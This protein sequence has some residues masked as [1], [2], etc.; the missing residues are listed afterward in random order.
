MKAEKLDEVVPEAMNGAELSENGLRLLRTLLAAEL[1]ADHPRIKLR[2]V[3]Q[4]CGFRNASQLTR[5]FRLVFRETPQNFR[6]HFAAQ[7]VQ[8][9]ST[10]RDCLN[11]ALCKLAVLAGRR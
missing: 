1:I 11:R 2:E 3:A 6:K 9:R 5:H 4:L 8:E 7:G 10:W